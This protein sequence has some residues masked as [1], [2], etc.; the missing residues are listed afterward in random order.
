MRDQTA[1]GAM[2]L[3]THLERVERAWPRSARARRSHSAGAASC[4]RSWHIM[5]RRP[6][7]SGL[8]RSGLDPRAAVLTLGT[9]LGGP[10]RYPRPHPRECTS[11]TGMSRSARDRRRS[12]ASLRSCGAGDAS[13]RSMRTYC[14]RLG[15]RRH[16]EWLAISTSRPVRGCFAR[17]PERCGRRPMLCR[18][19][20]PS[21]C[22]S[23]RAIW[24][25]C[26]ASLRHHG[27]QPG[28]TS[29]RSGSGVH[30]DSHDGLTQRLG[31]LTPPSASA[32]GVRNRAAY[33][34][35]REG[36]YWHEKF[37]RRHRAF[38]RQ[39]QSGGIRLVARMPAAKGT[40]SETLLVST[41]LPSAVRWRALLRNVVFT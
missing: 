22:P 6:F 4:H 16:R 30:G 27:D 35:S 21:A 29:G 17:L 5:A 34:A 1:T 20:S 23:R 40:R 8:R 38:L 36:A 31:A 7:Q 19:I 2:P 9:E 41:H 24:P 39:R 3:Y 14:C 33:A 37:I 25:I 32:P 18:R 15:I 13:M 11:G 28:G 10:A 26:A 12:D